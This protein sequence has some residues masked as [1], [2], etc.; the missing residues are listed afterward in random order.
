MSPVRTPSGLVAIATR[1]PTSASEVCAVPNAFVL[2][3]IDVQDPGN[4]GALMRTAEAGGMTGMFVSGAS[5]NPFSW[6]AIRGSMGSALRTARR[7]RND[8]GIRDDVPA[9]AEA[10]VLVAAVPRGG[11]DPDTID[12]R[13]RVA[14]IIGGEG[15]GLP[16][17]VTRAVRRAGLHSDGRSRGVLERRR[18]RCHSRLRGEAKQAVVGS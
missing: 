7:R 17:E 15:A 6:K 11:E 16:D 8:D 13:G 10:S 1:R 2:V 4:V 14:L 12:W 3:A 5:A 9:R 18:C